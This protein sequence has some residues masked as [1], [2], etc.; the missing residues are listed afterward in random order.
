MVFSMMKEKYIKFGIVFGIMLLGAL[1]SM[2]LE[3]FYVGSVAEFRSFLWLIV[4]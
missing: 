4:L 3:F 2:C 1:V